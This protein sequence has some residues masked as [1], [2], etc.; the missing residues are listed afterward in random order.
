MYLTLQI[1]NCINKQC[2]LVILPLSCKPVDNRFVSTENNIIYV[3]WR[4]LAFAIIDYCEK[5][6]ATRHRYE[7][8]YKAPYSNMPLIFI[9]RVHTN[10]QSIRIDERLERVPEYIMYMKVELKSKPVPAFPWTN[11]RKR[12]AWK[13]TNGVFTKA[14]YKKNANTLCTI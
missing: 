13:K 8:Q 10:T 5:W 9:S 12:G 2:V 11:C 14:C 4:S 3:L 1:E 6:A 7:P